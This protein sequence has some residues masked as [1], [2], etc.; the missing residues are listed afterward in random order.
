MERTTC[1]FCNWKPD[2]NH[3]HGCPETKR[4]AEIRKVMVNAWRMGYADAIFGTDKYWPDECA[5][6]LGYSRG[7]EDLKKA[8]PIDLDQIRP[9]NS[10]KARLQRMFGRNES[11]EQADFDEEFLDDFFGP[12]A[13]Q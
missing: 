6:A 9:V 13:D 4:D 2:Q 12:I 3:E 8:V 7:Q 10:D 1:E 5:Q 11:L